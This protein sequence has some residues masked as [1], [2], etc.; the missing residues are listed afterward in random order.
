MELNEI[1]NIKEHIYLNF[2]EKK[3]Y[4]KKG[5]LGLY[6]CILKDYEYNDYIY[7]Y[8]KNI[9]ELTPDELVSYIK[10]NFDKISKKYSSITLSISSNDIDNDFIKLL[11][12]IPSNIPIIIE[13]ILP[14]NNNYELLNNLL[15]DNKHKIYVKNNI[16]NHNSSSLELLV[17][18][19]SKGKLIKE[20]YD[21]NT[22]KDI[23]VTDNYNNELSININNT[24][25][26]SEVVNKIKRIS[27]FITNNFFNTATINI[28]ITDIRLFKAFPSIINYLE[29]DEN[30]PSDKIKYHF[31]LDKIDNFS[32]TR[33]FTFHNFTAIRTL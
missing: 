2:D 23:Y 32:T 21:I 18:A 14:N 5:I 29:T 6:A 27:Y 8:N 16:S 10:K 4:V 15:N 28:N 13:L 33:T 22:N 17:N 30:F 31:I 1:N 26:V 25:K 19:K 12:E 7:E 3:E 9:S 24:D 11:D 20:A